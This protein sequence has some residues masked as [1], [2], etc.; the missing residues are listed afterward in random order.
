LKEKKIMKIKMMNPK[1][2][3]SAQQEKMMQTPTALRR[4]KF[5][6]LR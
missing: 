2:K 4:S 3:K 1:R 5:S 6:L